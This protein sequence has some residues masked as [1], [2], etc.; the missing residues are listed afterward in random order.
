MS[1]L[2]G[3]RAPKTGLPELLAT[4]CG[5]ALAAVCAL[6]L[7]EIQRLAAGLWGLLAVL[8]AAAVS[9]AL[10]RAF[11]RLATIVPSGAALLAYLSRA[12]G[13]RAG[14][15]LALPYIGMTLFLV[16]SEATLS[17]ELLSRRWPL[18]VPLVALAFL[19]VTW[20]VCRAGLRIGYALQA[21][22]TWL[23]VAG[24]TAASL[25][26]LGRA[27]ADG[28]LG[29]RLLPP[30]PQPDAFLAACAQALFL[31]MG[32][33]LITAQIEMTDAVT[34]GRALRR[35]V[36]VLA[37]TYGLLV[38]G[39]ACL[40]GAHL[41]AAGPRIVPQLALA[42]QSAGHVGALALIVLSWLASFTSFNGALLALSRCVAALAA[43]GVLPRALMRI[44]PRSLV[45]RRALLLLLGLALAATAAVQAFGLLHASLLAAAASAALAYG[46]VAWARERAPFVET[47]RGTL[48]RRAGQALGVL[49][50]L[51]AV[52]VFVDGGAVVARA[53]AVLGGA[54]L[55]AAL[56][57]SRVTPAGRAARVP[58][59][60]ARPE[61]V[62]L[63]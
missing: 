38:L 4:S 34:L 39:F 12:Y 49:L 32:F 22:A 35:S 63:S 61:Q 31:F 50:A 25:T 44:E 10:A 53:L 27:W 18:P 1:A 54:L 45:P 20:G 40:D 3:A 43:Q 16:G 47:T 36:G 7:F 17:A 5:T 13:R 60:A 6:G 58:A 29:A 24:L 57:A 26:A 19:L 23:L 41:A 11:T 55:G 52:G 33:E 56:L 42:E 21:S 59:A 48:R 51:L 30:A 14:L 2:T 9:A 62:A 46:A 15:L 28:S 8:V 37:A